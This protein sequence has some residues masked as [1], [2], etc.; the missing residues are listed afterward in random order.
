MSKIT[1]EFD[2][3]DLIDLIAIT[4]AANATADV[5]FTNNEPFKTR[6]D[7]LNEKLLTQAIENGLHVTEGEFKDR[8]RDFQLS[9]FAF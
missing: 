8:V 6:S 4:L 1:I 5:C 3:N 7:E 2:R 9:G